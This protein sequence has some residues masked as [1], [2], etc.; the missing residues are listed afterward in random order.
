L[1]Q[2][3]D[4]AIDMGDAGTLI[5]RCRRDFAISSDSVQLK[6]LSHFWGPL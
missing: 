3:A 4:G 1:V 6:P 2:I 5:I